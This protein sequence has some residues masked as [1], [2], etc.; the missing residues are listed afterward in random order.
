[1]KYIYSEK[2]ENNLFDINYK[3]VE[4]IIKSDTHKLK[5]YSFF[6]MF[7][8]K[9]SNKSFNENKVKSE[10]DLTMEAHKDLYPKNVSWFYYDYKTD[11]EYYYRV[12]IR[13][14]SENKLLKLLN[15]NKIEKLS[16]LL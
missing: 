2:L 12:F 9:L 10:F 3:I 8:W 6:I 16:I 11:K 15:R 13:S 14:S 5:K 4:G 1:M 7:S